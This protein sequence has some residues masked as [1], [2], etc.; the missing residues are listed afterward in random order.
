MFI[1]IKGM[2]ICPIIIATHA[3]K[4]K[5]TIVLGANKNGK[6]MIDRERWEDKI[7]PTVRNP[8]GNGLA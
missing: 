1:Y 2:Q 8:T 5:M 4:Y 3:T 6:V 7:D